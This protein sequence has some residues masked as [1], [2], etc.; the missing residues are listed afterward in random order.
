MTMP[1]KYSIEGGSQGEISFLGSAYAGTVYEY[2]VNAPIQQPYFE[3]LKNAALRRMHYLWQCKINIVWK[4]AARAKYPR[5]QANTTVHVLHGNKP[6]RK[7]E[8][9]TT[10]K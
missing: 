6:G 4:V 9:A 5:G 3:V 8:G 2:R 1:N 10:V 7:F